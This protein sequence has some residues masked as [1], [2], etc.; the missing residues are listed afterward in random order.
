MGVGNGKGQNMSRTT[1][2]LTPPKIKAAGVG[3]HAD[4]DGLYLQVTAGKDGRRRNWVFRFRAGGKERY[5]G[6]GASAVPGQQEGVTL[7]AAR[8]AAALARALLR[9]GKD[10]IAARDAERA[11]A[12][13]EIE[14]LVAAAAGKKNFRQVFE[15]YFETKAK[16]L[17][18]ARHA[19]Q[20]RSTLRTYAGPIMDR[21]IADI[22]PD[23]VLAVL[24]PIWFEKPETA[25]RVLQRMRAVFA[26]A[27]VRKLR[28]SANP[29]DGVAQELGT[30]HRKVEHHPAL[31]Y[32]EVP[33]FLARLEA[34]NSWAAT[35]FAFEW[36][37]LTA[38]RSGET[39][40]A[41]WAEIDEAAATWT[42]PAARMKSRK[43][44][45]VPLSPRCLEILRMLRRVYPSAPSDLLFPSMKP[46]APLSDMTLTK[47]LRDM[48]LADKATVHGMRS[49]FRDWATEVAKVREVVA[50]AALAHTVRDKTEASYRRATYFDDRKTLMA[51]WATFC[52][53][54]VPT[55][56]VVELPRR[57]AL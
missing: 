16:S 56:T 50:E 25:K 31:P 7:A 15:T 5:M 37:I 10:P 24:R 36:L 4:G 13:A 23:E 9:E 27:S 14:A 54:P 20:W 12:R 48:G 33:D 51:A 8:E 42:I 46:G 2:R 22:G 29:T 38:T 55:D 30:R 11:R 19:A 47:V 43:A 26:S 40:L 41:R 53:K 44:H 21:P 35:R 17:S 3:W 6:L 18:N 49:A 34:T 57:T 1:E 32:A 45:V 39:R 52:A 28:T